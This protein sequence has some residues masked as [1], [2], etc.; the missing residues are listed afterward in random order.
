MS[1][2]SSGSPVVTQ[3]QNQAPWSGAQPYLSDIYSRANVMMGNN[4]GYQPYTGA[5]QAALDPYVGQAIN[6]LI[7]AGS[8]Y[9]G[10]GGPIGVPQAQALGQQLIQ[11][12]GLNAGLQGLASQLSA[13]TDPNLQAALDV[14]NQRIGNQIASGMSGAGRY[15]SGQM[16]D[17][18]SRALAQS[19]YPVLAQDVARREGQLQSIYQGGL[20]TAGQWAQA[21]PGLFQA[22]QAPS[23]LMLGAG[24]YM[25]DRAQQDLNA[26]IALYNAQQAYPWQE[27]ERNMA[28]MAG[29]GQLGGT[30]VTSQTPMQAGLTQRL[31]GGALVGGGLGSAIPGI[32]TGLGAL[33]GGLLGGFL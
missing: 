2:G 21:E 12:Q 15:G 28:I 19:S 13:G 32:G 5:T 22:S 25:Q 24:Q 6:N 7:G 27:L 1:S 17:V 8:Y 3:T 26:Q 18:M 9:A 14:Q 10:Q 16:T 29:A 11:N 20:Q 23:Q 33:G 30:T 31:L 4:V